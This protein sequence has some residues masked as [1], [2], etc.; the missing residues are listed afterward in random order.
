MHTFNFII[1]RAVELKVR[2]GLNAKNSYIRFISS[3]GNHP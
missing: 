1:C 3:L 2:I